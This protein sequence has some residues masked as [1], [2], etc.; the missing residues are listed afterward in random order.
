VFSVAVPRTDFQTRARL[1]TLLPPGLSVIASTTSCGAGDGLQ[2][3]HA[4][5]A[6]PDGVTV[7]YAAIAAVLAR[8]DL[9]TGE[10]LA[11]SSLA[12]FADREQRAWPGTPVAAARAGLSHSGFLTARERLVRRGL[13]VVEERGHSRASTLALL[14]ARSGPWWDGEINA[15]LFEAVLGYSRTAGAARA[16]LASLAALAGSDG[17]VD[18]L[19]TATLCR[20]A[21]LA[22]STYRRARAALVASGEAVVAADGGGRGRTNRWRV[23]HP[24]REL[25]LAAPARAKRVPAP[26]A[27]TRPLVAAVA[28]ELNSEASTRAPEVPAW[29]V[30]PAAAGAGGRGP[31]LVGHRGSD[32]RSPEGTVV[33]DWCPALSRVSD[34]RYPDPSGVSGGRCPDPSGVSQI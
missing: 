25:G 15:E 18:G 26:R 3:D 13:V 14:F 34:G 27:A 4:R 23:P 1:Y 31:R 20:A 24:N 2:P 19:S 7:S 6:Y 32:E 33:P 5:H 17:L 9:S 10:R 22:D 28:H 21:G 8:D 30:R 11:A 16:L 29:A 12:S